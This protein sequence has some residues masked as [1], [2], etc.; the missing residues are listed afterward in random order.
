MTAEE[1][2]ASEANRSELKTILE[3]PVYRQAAEA[4][5]V[6]MIPHI[7]NLG[8]GDA[9]IGNSRMQQ[10]AGMK[11]LLKELGR[12]TEAPVKRKQP[13][14]RRLYT[15]ADRERLSGGTDQPK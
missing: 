15:E 6:E 12:L 13:E 1:F 7:D 11:H 2:T 14:P 3:N 5:T 9:A 10:L 4:I 8:V